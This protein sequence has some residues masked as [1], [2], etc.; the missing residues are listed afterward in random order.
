ML[1]V[2][3]VAD[4]AILLPSTV[5]PLLCAAMGRA[6]AAAIANTMVCVQCVIDVVLFKP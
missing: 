5:L 1:C 4:C 6:T 2:W 3:C